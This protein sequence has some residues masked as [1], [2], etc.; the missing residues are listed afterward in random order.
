MTIRGGS[1]P[2]VRS[3]L[4]SY[5]LGSPGPG[6]DRRA[7]A[8]VVLGQSTGRDQS[9]P[10][11]HALLAPEGRP[12]QVEPLDV[13]ELTLAV[14]GAA[15]RVTLESWTEPRL[16]SARFGWRGFQV[17]VASWE[18]PLDAAFFG[19]LGVVEERG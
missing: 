10:V 8:A 6:R 19:S 17:V 16:R 15:V 18:L 3:A 11:R 4:H 9:V 1:G 12:D 5:L 14:D 2:A 7:P 13:R